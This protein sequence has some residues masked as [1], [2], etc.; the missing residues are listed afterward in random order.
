[1]VLVV[2][3]DPLVLTVVAEMLQ[4]RLGAEV[5]RAATAQ[6]GLAILS[7]RRVDAIVSDFRMPGMQGIE[8]LERCGVLAPG[9][10]R[11]LMTG[12][13]DVAMAKGAVNEAHVDKMLL[14]PL[15]GEVLAAAVSDA[16]DRIAGDTHR[17]RA[18]ER[19][20]DLLDRD[21]DAG[22]L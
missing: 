17:Q 12:Y 5:L 8:F 9:A 13:A 22:R 3:D 20:A 1:M 19:A 2:D 7:A 14:K 10:A 6:E 18:F 11:V 21:S 16:I 15:N 4:L